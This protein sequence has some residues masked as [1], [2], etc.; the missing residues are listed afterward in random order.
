MIASPMI[1][2]IISILSHK[3]K[4]MRKMMYL[5]FVAIC[6]QAIGCTSPL[7]DGGPSAVPTPTPT[8]GPI[9][10]KNTVIY[11]SASRKLGN[12]VFM[13]SM[14]ITLMTNTGFLVD[15]NWDGNI[16]SSSGYGWY[17]ELQNAGGRLYISASTVLPVYGKT[18]HWNTY[19]GAL[20]KYKNVLANGT[21]I[22][23]STAYQST[24]IG[25]ALDNTSGIW[26]AAEMTPATLT[27]IGYPTNIA[28]P[29]VVS[30]ELRD[31]S[32][33]VHNRKWP[34][35]LLFS[36]NPAGLLS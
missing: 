19:I 24:T 12:A 5:L 31:S 32:P 33:F 36:G 15:I 13:D 10:S 30:F 20:Y 27:E 8:S 6:V 22:G 26:D 14:R 35:F 4:T 9:I 11:D 2:T 25:D 3:E 17:Y 18:C 23:V 21:V 34:D 1:L 29:L 28:L 7:T 16:D